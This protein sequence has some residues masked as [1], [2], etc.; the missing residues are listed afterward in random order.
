[1]LEYLE[2]IFLGY[3][4]ALTPGP[5]SLFVLKCGL[6]KNLKNALFAVLGILVGNIIYL[7]LVYFG[8]TNLSKNAYFL[9]IVSLFGGFYLLYL[10]IVSLREKVNLNIKLKDKEMDYINKS[11][12]KKTFLKALFTNLS[13]PKAILFFSSVLAPFLTKNIKLSLLCLYFGIAGAF[14]SIAFLSIKIRNLKIEEKTFQVVNKIIGILFLLFSYKLFLQ[15][16]EVLKKT[17]S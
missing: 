8:F 10:G 9:F 3:F 14:L 6:F 1:M 13:N 2:L 12:Y 4:A 16:Y 7:S 5:D 15:A 17:L 11:S